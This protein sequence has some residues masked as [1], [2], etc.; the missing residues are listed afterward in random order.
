MP[1]PASANDITEI[2]V[3]INLSEALYNIFYGVLGQNDSDPTSQ[4]Q[5]MQIWIKLAEDFET[6]SPSTFIGFEEKK[7]LKQRQEPNNIWRELSMRK[8]QATR[9]FLG[10]QVLNIYS[11]DALNFGYTFYKFS[12]RNEF[13]IWKFWQFGNRIKIWHLEIL[14]YD[15]RG[16]FF[17]EM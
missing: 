1:I 6:T 11:I 3:W 16:T 8:C 14:G 7:G 15:L 13:F 9:H 10:F 4:L 2:F 17:K 5:I 12:S